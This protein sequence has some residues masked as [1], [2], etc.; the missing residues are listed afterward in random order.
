MTIE[1]RR[2]REKTE[3]R[4][5][6]LLKAKE[7]LVT[8]GP[9]KLS[10]RKIA[11]AAEYSPATLYIYFKD[12][13]EIIH[14]LM[15]MGFGM[16]VG[17]MGDIWNIPN[18]V[19]RMYALGLGYVHFGLDHPDWYEIMFV[20]PQPFNHLERCKEEWC[21]GIALFESVVQVSQEI[22]DAHPTMRTDAR[23]LALQFW[24][25]AHGLVTLHNAQRLDIVDTKDHRRLAEDTLESMLNTMIPQK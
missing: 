2:E 19:H 21:N 4:N 25:M 13:D 20:S 11:Q 3:L 7:I 6:I 1:T 8:E 14:A 10:M 24:S 18:P 15:E 9:D 5:L 12:K 17:S 22:I 23:V 16:M